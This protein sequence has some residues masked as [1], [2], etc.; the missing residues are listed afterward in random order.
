ME[1]NRP[2]LGIPI[3]MD[4]QGVGK[5]VLGKLEHLNKQIWNAVS[6]RIIHAMISEEKELKNSY[7]TVK[8]YRK[9]RWKKALQEA[10]GN[11]RNAYEL[12]CS[13]NFY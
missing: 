7:K 8:E 6:F 9:I 2:A 5:E 11:K 10:N 12:I 4:I 13:E 1:C 3:G